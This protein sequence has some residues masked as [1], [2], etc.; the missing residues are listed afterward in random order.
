MKAV[1]VVPPVFD[2]YHTPHR[3]AGLGAEIVLRLLR[4]RGWQ[5]KLLNFPAQCPKGVKADLPEALNHLRPYLLAGESGRL[6][7]F[8]RYQRFGPSLEECRRQILDNHPDLVFISCFAFCYAETALDLAVALGRDGD[9]P[10][11]ACGGAG[12]SAHPGYFMQNAAVDFAFV[13]EA[14]VALPLFLEVTASENGDFERV[15]NLFYKQRQRTVAPTQ[16]TRT[17]ADEIAFVLTKT[18][19]TDAA[20][21]YSTALS[22][23]CPKACRFCSNFIS[24]GRRFRTVPLEK[25]RRALADQIGRGPVDCAKQVIVNFE[26]DN[27]LWDPDYFFSVLDL[28][29]AIWPRA[30]FL[31]ENGMDYTLLTPDLLEKLLQYGMKQFNFSLVSNDT[32]LL[33]QEKRTSD[34]R[35]YETIIGRLQQADIPCI[36]YF[37]CGLK[38]DSPEKT[39]DNLAYLA[40]QPTRVGI[41]LFYPVP[42]LPDFRDPALFDDVRPVLCAGSSAWPWNQSLS[43]GQMI[44]AFRLSRLVDLM[45]SRRRTPWDELLLERSLKDQRLYTLSREGR[46]KVVVPVPGMDGGMVRLFFERCRL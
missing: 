13:G 8:S 23:G 41:S 18:A 10:I 43:T 1:V 2:F 6:A 15:P 3:T 17:V 7:F 33:R 44:T 45:K 30:G 32:D 11:I 31:A 14:E 25:I 28:F 5:A 21:F 22:R 12:V 39:V 42:G 4:D 36:T 46:Q 16:I 38:N 26:D 20:V 9:R 37:I 29:K 35:R 19:E 34:R 40:Q 24:Q 27:F